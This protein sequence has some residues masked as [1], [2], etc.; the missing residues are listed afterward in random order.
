MDTINADY[1]KVIG[2]VYFELYDTFSIVI[3]IN[4][5]VFMCDKR[6]FSDEPQR[7]DVEAEFGACGAREARTNEEA[8][9]IVRKTIAAYKRIMNADIESDCRRLIDSTSKT[10]AK[11][12]KTGNLFFEEAKV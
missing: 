5:W 2:S 9:E 7:A 6:W 8:N 4:D 3:P 12:D 10:V 11:I 1:T